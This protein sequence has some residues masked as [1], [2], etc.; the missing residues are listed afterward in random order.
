M[1]KRL[2]FLLV[3]LM[4]LCSAVSAK[5]TPA[6]GPT[7]GNKPSSAML[8]AMRAP[9]SDGYQLRFCGDAYTW[10]GYPVESKADYTMFIYITP[11]VATNLAGNKLTDITLCPYI[12]SNIRGLN[13][14]VFVSEDITGAPITSTDAKIVN[15][16]PNQQRVKMQTVKLETPYTIKADTGFY[17]GCTIKGC[18][19][20]DYPICVDALAPTTFA[21]EFMISGMEG[22]G[23]AAADLGTNIVLY[24]STQGDKHSLENVFA[25]SDISLGM[26]TL[27]IITEA[28]N[29]SL[30]ISINNIGANSISSLE[31]DYSY[32]SGGYKTVK[33]AID[34]PGSSE[35][36]VE[37]ALDKPAPGRDTLRVKNIKIDGIDQHVAANIPYI[38]VAGEGYPRKFVVEEGTATGCGFCPRGIVGLET[39]K[40]KYPDT[41]IGIAIHTNW[42]GADPMTADSYY[43]LP[44]KYFT[45]LPASIVNRDPI[46]N[47]DPNAEELEMYHML[48]S[49][50]AAP[51]EIALSASEYD[52]ETNTA[53]ITATTTFAIDDA[54][55]DYRL[56]FVLVEDGF[57]SAQTN[58]FSGGQYGKMGGWES[59][60]SP[61]PWTFSD[62]ARDIIGIFGIE[63]SIPAQVKNGEAYTYSVEMP[64]ENAFIT[65][66]KVTQGDIKDT[67]VVALLID[68]RSGI[69]LNAARIDADKY[70][71]LSAIPSAI[72]DDTDAPVEYFNLQGVR[73]PAGCDLPGGVYIKKQGA[74]VKKIVR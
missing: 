14:S 18:T 71:P 54:N 58:S 60:P 29:P 52:P 70:Y 31:L 48:W 21:G 8:K 43:D 64:F 22:V 38:A 69:I 56:A 20:D 57:I 32:G 66:G 7:I 37:V 15:G 68:G 2:L 27:P 13:G 53:E 3:L 55:A 24:A 45:G 28:S 61:T 74:T 44:A 5:F 36:V 10:Y 65:Y 30:L 41:F 46:Y 4:S 16:F 25:I 26:Y 17:F 11:E 40:E 72:N 62:V 49:T 33:T 51:A 73:I 63:G 47:G 1:N 59:K 6:A 50:Q 39:M 23:S 19:S 42:F 34:I 12:V 35:N 9:T 67:R